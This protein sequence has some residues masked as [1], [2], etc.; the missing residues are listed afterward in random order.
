MEDIDIWRTATLLIREHGEEAGYVAF[1][2][3]EDRCA[4]NDVL[5]VEAWL[6]IG[7]AIEELE[8]KKPR[9][10]EALN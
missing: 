2:R 10:G 3:A 8:R 5:G 6:R 4:K 9:E 1:G 7:R